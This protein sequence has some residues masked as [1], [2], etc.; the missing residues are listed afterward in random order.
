[1]TAL[2]LVDPP[3][4]PYHSPENTKLFEWNTDLA[5]NR[6]LVKGACGVRR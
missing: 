4:H 5:S 2:T 6:N 3:L 1:M